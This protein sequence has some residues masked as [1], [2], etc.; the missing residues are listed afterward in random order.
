MK[1]QQACSMQCAQ[2]DAERKLAQRMA[3]ACYANKTV[4]HL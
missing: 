1:Q 3:Q 4:V 2:V